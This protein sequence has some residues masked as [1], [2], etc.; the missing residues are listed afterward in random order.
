MDRRHPR[1]HED[2]GDTRGRSLVTGRRTAAVAVADA[3]PDSSSATRV[4][5][6]YQPSTWKKSTSGATSKMVE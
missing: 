5:R 2:G 3:Y 6:Q 1:R 4:T